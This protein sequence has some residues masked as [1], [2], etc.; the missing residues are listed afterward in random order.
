MRCFPNDAEVIADETAAAVE[1]ASA[2]TAGDTPAGF[3][4]SLNEGLDASV[5]PHFDEYRDYVA[6]IAV[7]DSF[8]GSQAGIPDDIY[9]AASPYI[10]PFTDICPVIGADSYV[11]W[12][13]ANYPGE[14]FPAE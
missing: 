11:D 7:A 12:M 6:A 10:A 3:D 4:E 9:A 8:M 13:N 14:E 2:D 5:Y 1:D